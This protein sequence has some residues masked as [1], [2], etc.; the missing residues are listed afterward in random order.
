MRGLA[1]NLPRGGYLTILFKR[2]VFKKKPEMV[3]Y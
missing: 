3:G 2:A 1:D